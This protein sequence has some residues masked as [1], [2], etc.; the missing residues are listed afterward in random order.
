MT[1]LIVSALVFT[2]FVLGYRI[3][4]RFIEKTLV[5]PDNS[6]QPPSHSRCDGMDFSPAK[7]VFL[8]GHHFASIAGAGPIIGPILAVSYFGWG[9]TTLWITLG[10]VFFGAV[11]DY[12]SLM[13]SVRN[14]GKGISEIAGKAIGRRTRLIFALLL[15]LTL[16]FIIAVFASSAAR[17]L[18]VKPE[19]VIPTAGVCL[20]AILLGIAVYRYKINTVL[21]S[22]AAIAATYFL[23][24]LGYHLPL[25][26]PGSIGEMHV[27]IVLVI[28]ILFTYCAIASLLP[29][30]LLLQPRD[31]LS[32]AQLFIILFLGIIALF[33]VHPDFNAPF[34]SGNL[35]S[36]EMPIWPILFITVACGAISGFH[37]MVAT[38]TTSKQLDRETDG[39]LVGYGG[40]IMEG[41]LAF[42][43]VMV[44]SAGLYWGFA[45]QGLSEQASLL[46]FHT[47]MQDSWI[48]AFGSGFGNIVS[49]LNLPFITPAVAA[50][51]GAVMVKTF[52]IT[53]LDTST[54]L[55]RF[56]FVETIAGHI[57]V[58]KN[59]LISTAVLLV[60]SYFLAVTNSYA[61]IWKLFG[62]SNQLIAAIALIVI[63]A[64]LTGIKR[65]AI[66]T[67]VPAVFMSLTTLASLAW[68]TFNPHSGY[69]SVKGQEVELGIIS[70]VLIFF[71]LI[72]LVDGIRAII[73]NHRNGSRMTA[74][75]GESPLPPSRLS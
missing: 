23:I 32:A 75:N 11:H 28:S 41:V 26:L 1:T 43:V 9:L 50:L 29:V 7:P 27:H 48:V 34:Y 64:Y 69:F 70:L 55:G 22:V 68:G 21:S 4:G 15:W 45:P 67:L 57:P 74:R 65:P 40:M 13:L 6:R 62:S 42:L 52:I 58:L 25:S 63:S 46:Y 39:K 56:V 49:Q 17:A 16:V 3:Y 35:F 18:V 10:S 37:T 5:K 33:I 73:F 31:F 38:G 30:W 54:R 2:W 72:V 8:W 24:W 51:L 60:P 47:A 53:S 12:L 59:K 14:Q 66:Y 19:L 20:I 61:T 71:S 44:V 36:G